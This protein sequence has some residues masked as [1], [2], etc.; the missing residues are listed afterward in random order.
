MTNKNLFRWT[1]M[2]IATLKK[3]T[4]IVI[5][6]LLALLVLSGC[7]SEKII[8][9]PLVT[10][11]SLRVNQ[12]LATNNNPPEFYLCDYVW[13][14]CSEATYRWSGEGERCTRKKGK[15][16]GVKKDYRNKSALLTMKLR[17]NTHEN[18]VEKNNC[19]FK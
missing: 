9:I 12:K 18:T 1:V 2:M 14:S 4:S 8:H 5:I 17:K 6:F 16:K 3:T 7:Q 19:I 15:H 10:D 11:Y 13:N